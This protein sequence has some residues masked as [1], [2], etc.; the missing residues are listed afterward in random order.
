[1][2]DEAATNELQGCMENLKTE[3]YAE[4]RTR[5]ENEI[6]AAE[7]RRKGDEDSKGRVQR[8]Q[9]LLQESKEAQQRERSDG[10]RPIRGPLVLKGSER[11]TEVNGDKAKPLG[12]SMTSL[13]SPLRLL[14]DKTQSLEVDAKYNDRS[15]P[16]RERIEPLPADCRSHIPSQFQNTQHVS[17]FRFHVPCPT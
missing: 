1:M 6:K 8:F 17:Y 2:E 10:C 7:A 13:L 3:A 11:S 9:K 4:K 15:W 5:M 16:R 12:F 14:Q